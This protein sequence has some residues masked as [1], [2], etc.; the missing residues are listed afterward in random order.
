VVTVRNAL[1]APEFEYLREDKTCL[2]SENT[3]DDL[4]LKIVRAITKDFQITSSRESRIDVEKYSTQ[5]MTANF[6]AGI[7]K[8][9]GS[10]YV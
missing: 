8:A 1:H 6:V 9:L 10:K 2:T 3:P 7:L 5:T 4:G